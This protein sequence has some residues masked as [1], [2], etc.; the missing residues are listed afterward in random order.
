MERR[1]NLKLDIEVLRVSELLYSLLKE[2]RLKFTK[3]LDMTVTYHDPCHLTRSMAVA[4]PEQK[5]QRVYEPQRAVIDAIPGGR[6]HR[7]ITKS[8]RFLVL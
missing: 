1:F 7:N 4:L 6:V 2:G 5:R 3:E 8:R